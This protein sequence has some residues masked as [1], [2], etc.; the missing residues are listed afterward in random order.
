MARAAVESGDG[1]GFPY[2]SEVVASDAA[3]RSDIRTARNL[4]VS[5]RRFLGWEPRQITV[6]RDDG[7][8]VTVTEPEYDVWEQQVQAAYTAWLDDVCPGCGWPTRLGLWTGEPGGPTRD[9]F[10]ASYRQC[11]PCDVLEN[12]V[13]Q[14]AANDRKVVEKNPD[15][16]PPSTKH[17]HWQVAYRVGQDGGR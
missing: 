16:L 4:G 1:P 8:V 12:A 15:L 17:R 10:V 2:V 7:T 9:M 3:L 5:L 6:T 11:V 14:V 13:N